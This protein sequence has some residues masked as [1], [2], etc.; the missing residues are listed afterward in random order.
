MVARIVIVLVVLLEPIK[1]CRGNNDG[2]GGDN[3]NGG[4]CGCVCGDSGGSCVYGGGDGGTKDG[5]G[6]CGCGGSGG[7]Y[8]CGGGSG[9][10]YGCG[11]G[12]G[13]SGS[14]GDMIVILTGKLVELDGAGGK[15]GGVGAESE[16][17]DA[18]AVVEEELGRA[19]QDKRVVDS[20]CGVGGGGPHDVVG[21]LVPQHQAV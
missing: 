8:G 20:Y 11:G 5:S 19:G 16:S 21:L 14:G 3:N 13:C 7:G 17:R 10:G 1:G 15:A 12:G 2:R 18:V 4:S 9:G 6:S